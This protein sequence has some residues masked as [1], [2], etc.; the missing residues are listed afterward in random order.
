ML[1]YVRRTLPD[2]LDKARAALRP[3]GVLFLENTK[4]PTTAGG[5]DDALIFSLMS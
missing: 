5:V 4:P 2:V 1:L 3:G